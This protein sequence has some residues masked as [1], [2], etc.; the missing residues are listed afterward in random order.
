M[1]MKILIVEDEA[2]L[3][4]SMDD[5]L[6]AVG[7]IVVG[8]ARDPATAFRIARDSRPDL[9]LVDLTL[10]RQTSGAD[11][12]RHLLKRHG[13]PAIFVSGSPGDCK[14]VGFRIGA[15]GCLAKPFMADDLVK[16][17]DVAFRIIQQQQPE[18]VPP[19]MELYYVV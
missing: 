4:L 10:A 5:A 14:K 2:M 16:A 8:L 19:N 9:A 12:A 15:L 17:V 1:G 7:H 18:R 3:A 6:T 11:V 13:V